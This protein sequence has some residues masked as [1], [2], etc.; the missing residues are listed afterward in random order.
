MEPHNPTREADWVFMARNQEKSFNREILKCL[1]VDRE[2]FETEQINDNKM[3]SWRASNTWISAGCVQR[4]APHGYVGRRGRDTECKHPD[5]A[6][7]VK[8]KLE[9]MVL[10]VNSTT[11]GS[12]FPPL[13]AQKGHLYNST[14]QKR[15]LFFLFCISICYMQ[16]KLWISLG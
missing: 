14:F 7:L 12:F 2:E 11:N 16:P 4:A 1:P 13:S 8:L 15:C 10:L 9:K 6:L 3:R 5:W